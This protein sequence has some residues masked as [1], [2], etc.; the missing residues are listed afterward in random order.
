MAA[1]VAGGLRWRRPPPIRG[2]P[3]RAAVQRHAGTASSSAPGRRPGPAAPAA[4]P[5]VQWS[6]CQGGGR[7]EGLPV[8][9]RHGPARPEPSRRRHASGWRSTG[10]R[11]PGR[12]SDRSWSTRAVPASPG[13]T[14]CPDVVAEMPADLLARFDIVGFDPPGVDRTA[15]ITCADGAGLDRYFS[16]RSRNRRRPPASPPWW[17]PTGRF[18]AGLP[19]AERRR[20]AL[21]EHRRR[22][23]GHGRAA[24]GPRRRQAHLPGFLVRK[25]CWEPPTPISSRPTCGPWSSTACSTRPCRPSPRSTQQSAALD[26]QLQAFFAACAHV[27]LRLAARPAIRRPPSRP[28]WTGSA[29]TRCRPEAPSRRVGPAAVLYGHG[30]R[31]STGRRR[32]PSWPR[33]S[34]RPARRRDRLPGALR[35]LHRPPEQRH[36][37]QHLRGQRRRQLPG[38]PGPHPRPAIQADASRPPRRPRPCSG[39]W[40]STGRSSARSGRSRR[41]GPIGPIRAAGSPPIVVVGSTGDPVTPV[42]L[43]PGAGRRTG[44]RRAADPGRRRPHGYG[45]SACIRTEVDRYLTSLA[46]PPRRAPAAQRLTAKLGADDNPDRH[47]RDRR[48]DPGPR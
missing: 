17:P 25:P 37:Q 35:R 46:V 24:G 47:R 43:G 21:R 13:S 29:P 41:P 38:H 22:R 28:W 8:R 20:A 7:P 19:G 10:I 33:P 3:S 34:R 1:V 2:A 18:G 40:T 12:R 5:T 32:G 15:P 9:H 4:P 42:Q 30:R 31:R 44:P 36:L 48:P 27:G 6:A 11:R 16:H 26:A 14:S 39:C 45:S 23:P